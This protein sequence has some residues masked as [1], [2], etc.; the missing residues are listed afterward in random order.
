VLELTP[1]ERHGALVVV[2]LFA[3]GAGW[4]LWRA[5]HPRLEPLGPPTVRAPGAGEREAGAAAGAPAA[6][7]G[8][9]TPAA[10]VDLNRASAEELD[11]LPGIGPVLARRIVDHRLAHGPFARPEDLLAVRGIGPRSFAR[12]RPRVVV[13]PAG[14]PPAR[15]A[16]APTGTVLH[17]A[18][19][20]P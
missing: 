19:R 6:T 12:L 2:C 7:E 1:A 18:R 5:H 11:A 17:P 4:D 15:P 8:P 20:A 13:G 14:A 3:L 9:A 10:P 16:R